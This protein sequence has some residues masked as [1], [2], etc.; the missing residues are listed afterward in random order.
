[1]KENYFIK[2]E[3]LLKEAIKILLEKLGPVETNRFL[4][5]PVQKRV[6]SVKRHHLWQ[7]ILDKEKFYSEI[8]ESFFK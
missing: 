5:L 6:E 8:F 4:S 1:M 3:E 7:A 2:E